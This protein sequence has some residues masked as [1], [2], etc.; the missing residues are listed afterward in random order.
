VSVR[1][2]VALSVLSLPITLLAQK[3]S[4]VDPMLGADGGGNVFIG[5]ASK[6]AWTPQIQQALTLCRM[7]PANPQC[8]DAIRFLSNWV[9]SALAVQLTTF[10]VG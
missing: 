1:L 6:Y 5:L 8:S 3:A 4:E 2:A 9:R 10:P 7:S